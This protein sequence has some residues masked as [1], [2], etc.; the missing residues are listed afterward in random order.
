MASRPGRIHAEIP[1]NLPRPRDR[2]LTTTTA[3]LE[4]V[5]KVSIALDEAS[6]AS[7]K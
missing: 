2:S 5:Q 6:D 3:F 1:I 7:A 4:L